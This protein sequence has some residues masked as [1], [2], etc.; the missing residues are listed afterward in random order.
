MS[1]YGQH[2]CRFVHAQPGIW[3]T[4]AGVMHP[5]GRGRAEAFKLMADAANGA[6]GNV[7]PDG[8]LGQK[9]LDRATGRPRL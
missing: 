2:I 6:T 5:L 9:P 7:Q 3:P 8:G 1:R 4:G